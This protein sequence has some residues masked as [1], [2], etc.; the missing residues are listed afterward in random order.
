MADVPGSA[1]TSA[2]ARD[3]VVAV[4]GLVAFTRRDVR[5]A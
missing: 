5:S 2:A 4:S 1:L 3:A